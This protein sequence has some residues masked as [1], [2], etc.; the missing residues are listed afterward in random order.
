MTTEEKTIL[1]YVV[2]VAIGDGNLSNPNG[3]ATRLRI[4][5][6]TKY[7]A[8]V[9]RIRAA[10]KVI[11][12]KN[13]VSI[14][15]RA[16]TYID[17]S[18]YSNQWELL[19]GWQVGNGSK[20][21]QNVRLPTWIKA[22]ANYSKK[23]LKGL[24]ETDGCIYRD[25]SYLMASFTT[26]IPTLARDVEK[27]INSFAFKMCFYEIKTAHKLRYNIR[28]SKNTDQFLEFFGIKKD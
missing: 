17:I 4:T 6:D 10:I 18:C 25:R 19:L 23:C 2:G 3:R 27:I 22:D 12:P 28:I 20:F 8:L 5:C 1:A 26:V 24:F 13:K 7:P 9:E 11:L 16:K 15:N 14:V 21:D